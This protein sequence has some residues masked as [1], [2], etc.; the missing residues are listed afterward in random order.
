MEATPGRGGPMRFLGEEREVAAAVRRAGERGV[1]APGTA[2]GTRKAAPRARRLPGAHRRE[3]R[4][5][6]EMG[7]SDGQ[8]LGRPGWGTGVRTLLS[9]NSGPHLTLARPCPSGR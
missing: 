5:G 8:L 1:W 2:P 9:S 6:E 7:E 3:D 4:S